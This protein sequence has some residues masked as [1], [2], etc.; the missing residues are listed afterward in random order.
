MKLVIDI[1]EEV[2]AAISEMGLL[3]IPKDMQKSVDR[4]IQKGTPLPEGHGD[5]I[6]AQEE[7]SQMRS[8][9]YDTYEDYERAFDMLDKAPAVIKADKGEAE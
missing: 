4:A 5:L 3:R 2:R 9:N 8:Y 1:P 6:D 7:M